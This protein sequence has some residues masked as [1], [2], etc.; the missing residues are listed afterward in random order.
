MRRIATVSALAALAVGLPLLEAD[1]GNG[2]CRHGR[3]AAFHYA[4]PPAGFYAPSRYYGVT[5]RPWD[6]WRAYY[7]AQADVSGA[8]RALRGSFYSATGRA[9]PS[10]YFGPPTNY[11][12]EQYSLVPSSYFNCPLARRGDGI[13]PDPDFFKP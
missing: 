2:C 13:C 7:D 4:P 3:R 6:A 10:R 11:Y 12:A 8:R 5:A 9:V 1:A